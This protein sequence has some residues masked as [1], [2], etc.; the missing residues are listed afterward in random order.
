M[1]YGGERMDCIFCKI[2]AGELP[3]YKVYEDDYTFAF[4]DIN[5]ITKGHTLVLPKIHVTKLPELE[6]KYSSGLIGAVQKVT[7]AIEDSIK[8]E[9]LNIFVNQGEVAG[10]IVPHLHVHVVPRTTGDGLEFTTPKVEM[11]EEEFKEIS[12]KIASQIND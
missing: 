7:R 6:G 3:S 8:P 1:N 5:P 12:R 10:Q 4:L 9:G 11:I 2:I